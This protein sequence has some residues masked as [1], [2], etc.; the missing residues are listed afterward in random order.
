[1]PFAERLRLDRL[2]LSRLQLNRL[3]LRGVQLSHLQLSR[4]QRGVT[5][6][7]GVRNL[8]IVPTAFGWWWLAG[9][10]LLQVVAIQLQRN[11]PL[12]L[13]YLMLGLMLLVLH[14]THFNL[15]G[16]ELRCSSAEPGFAGEDLRYPLLLRSQCRREGVELGLVAV[17]GTAVP[18]PNAPPARAVVAIEPGEQLLQ[19]RWR[20]GQRGWQRPGRIRLQSTAPLGL[21]VCWGLWEPPLE[22]LVLPARRPGPVQLLDGRSGSPLRPDGDPGGGRRPESGQEGS[23]DWRELVPHRPEDSPSRLAWKVLAQGRGRHSKRFSGAEPQELL[24]APAEGVPRERALEH[25]S[26]RIWQLEQQ[27]ERYGLLLD[28]RRLPPGSGPQHRLRCLTVL[29]EAPGAAVR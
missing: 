2:Q 19:L 14:L 24:L 9:A 18:A 27:G 7:L 22:Q 17:T 12:L 16:L 28:G 20:A 25:L 11:G 10:G 23:D 3:Q 29:A 4:V 26:E 15:Q 8:Y 13:S 6:R 1:M 21:F 5:A